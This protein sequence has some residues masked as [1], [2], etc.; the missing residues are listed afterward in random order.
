[1]SRPT[2]II[3]PKPQ[4]PSQD[5]P[6]NASWGG[7]SARRNMPSTPPH[8]PSGG[9]IGGSP[10][11]RSDG[12]FRNR[13]NSSDGAFPPSQFSGTSSGGLS[14]GDETETHKPTRPLPPTRA[15]RGGGGNNVPPR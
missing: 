8:P 11:A 13:S 5:P 6:L 2:P 10:L 4:K 15:M 9:S 1:M 14:L 3:P 12:V 7:Q